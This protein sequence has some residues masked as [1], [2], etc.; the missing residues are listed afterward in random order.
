MTILGRLSD[1]IADRQPIA[2]R[3]LLLA[4]TALT[5]FTPLLLVSDE[6]WAQE[7]VI[8]GGSTEIV[9]GSG[10]GSGTQPNPWSMPEHLF[11]G[12]AG[13]GELRII[14]GGQVNTGEGGFLGLG[15]DAGSVTVTGSGS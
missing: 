12:G 14:K 2:M 4:T 7:I 5:L 8:E 6:A 10:G 15:A 11:I 1:T 3:H 13:S 9:D